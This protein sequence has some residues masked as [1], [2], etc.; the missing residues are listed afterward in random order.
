MS[1]KNK[2]CEYEVKETSASRWS[3]SEARRNIQT[4][5]LGNKTEQE[6]IC[7]GN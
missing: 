2:R 6:K 3:S 5:A 4:L 1:M 7:L